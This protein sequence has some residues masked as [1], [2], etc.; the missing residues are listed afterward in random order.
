MSSHSCD[1]VNNITVIFHKIA[2]NYSCTKKI[3]W[4]STFSRPPKMT[5]G[6]TYDNRMVEH[7]CLWDLNY[8]EKPERFTSILRRCEELQLLNR[9]IY[10][11]PRAA[12]K[13][14]LLMVHT[15]EMISI[16]KNTAGFSDEEALEQ[17][18]SKYD[19]LYIHPSTY[20]LSLLA[21]GSTVEL[22][23]NILDGKIKNGMAVIRPPGH[24]AMKSEYCGYC[25]YN[26][27]AIA[28][29][30]AL[31]NQGLKRILIVDWDIHHGQATQQ[32]F[33]D[34]P[35]VLYFS[36]HGY[37]NGA[38]WPHL[39][40]SDYHNI[41]R[42]AGL[43]Y[44]INIPMNEI[45]MG[46]SDYMAI[47]HQLILPI[48]YEFNPELVIVS[49][50]YDAALG[51]PEGEMEVTP[52]CYSHFT[53][54]LMGLANGRLA[55]VLE[56]GYCL[57][58]LSEGAA[59]TL[60]TLLGDPAPFIQNLDAPKKSAQQAI[61]SAMYVLR[62]HWNC[63][64]HLEE[65]N[66]QEIK[67]PMNL[68]EDKFWPRIEFV[69]SDEKPETY[70]TRDICPAQDPKVAA[71]LDAQLDD[72]IAST[73]LDTQPNR[74]GFSTNP[75]EPIVT[76]L[77]IIQRCHMMQTERSEI[78][79]AEETSG[80]FSNLIG[81][82]LDG[83][84]RSGIA[85][86]DNSSENL[87][88]TLKYAIDSRVTKNVMFI[89]MRNHP[90]VEIQRAF[91]EDV[92]ILCA[93]LYSPF[94]V[95]DVE[96]MGLNDS[97]RYIVNISLQT[98]CGDAEIFSSFFRVLLPIAYQFGPQLIVIAA[99]QSGNISAECFGQIIHLLTSLAGGRLSV[100]FEN[101]LVTNSG[102][103][104]IKSCVQ[105]L[106]GE[107]IGMPGEIYYRLHA[108]SVCTIRTV[109]KAH[110]PYWN[111]LQFNMGVPDVNVL[112]PPFMNDDK[113]LRYNPELLHY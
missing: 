81:S 91:Q 56:G 47:F 66:V 50:G 6:I 28:A 40:E 57:K 99:D 55:V 74:V 49:A 13:E 37:Q 31:D 113:V 17:L 30:Y 16:L 43:G 4:S 27:V 64:Q 107:P 95:D 21:A 102:I 15:P 83:T 77:E 110:N 59:L 67:D 109:I 84:C 32:M 61:M 68:P 7:K 36:I 62:R 75:A 82:I 90:D 105:A 87:I 78:S 63:L 25:F 24:H 94:A 10:I 19:F 100:T 89:D 38:F 92:R 106:L 1:S 34:D 58:S 11:K 88:K 79:I 97:K 85:I 98:N 80:T 3:I 71:E 111:A 101:S 104:R 96:L 72:L 44:N 73:C 23:S 20:D 93:S 8:N 54:S 103:N 69:G 65:F 51:C 48:A 76:Q 60:R 42:G 2:C 18:S 46:N 5:T 70:A 35:R 39:R 53:N 108:T 112:V 33:Y 9:C 29:Q 14:E 45:K 52:A 22:V 86:M 12:T 26:N 41:G